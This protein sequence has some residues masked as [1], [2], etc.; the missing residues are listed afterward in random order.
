MLVP[1][2]KIVKCPERK[3]KTIVIGETKKGTDG[4]MPGEPE[5]GGK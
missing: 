5:V 4:R 2:T 1:K 3:S